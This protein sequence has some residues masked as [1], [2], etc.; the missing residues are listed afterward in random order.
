MMETG[1]KAMKKC[2]GC[3]IKCNNYKKSC[4]GRTYDECP[5]DCLYKDMDN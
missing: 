4:P 2:M 3:C 5:Q 1:V